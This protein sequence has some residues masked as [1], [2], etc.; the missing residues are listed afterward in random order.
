MVSHRKPKEKP[1][2]QQLEGKIRVLDNE[3]AMLRKWNK[4]SDSAMEEMLKPFCDF[5]PMVK[6]DDGYFNPFTGDVRPPECECPVD[7]Q[8]GTEGCLAL[9]FWKEGIER[10]NEEERKATEDLVKDLN[11]EEKEGDF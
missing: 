3:V 6:N 8:F 5:C 10:Y 7:W 1:S 11:L 4:E 9:K 2:Y